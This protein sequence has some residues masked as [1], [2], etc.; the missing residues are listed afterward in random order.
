VRSLSVP[1]AVDHGGLNALA[2]GTGHALP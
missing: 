2:T 1:P